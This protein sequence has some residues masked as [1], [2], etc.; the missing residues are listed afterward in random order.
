[1]LFGLAGYARS[2]DKTD[3]IGDEP[4]GCTS[5]TWGRLATIDGSV[6]NLFHIPTT[7]HGPRS[8]INI[9]PAKDH[10]AGACAISPNGFLRHVAIALYVYDKVGEI[11]R[12][13]IRMH[14]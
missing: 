8:S 4:D 3:W 1:M 11:P 14:T 5:I 6:I 2:V 9:Q 13:A 10:P 12:W 7:A